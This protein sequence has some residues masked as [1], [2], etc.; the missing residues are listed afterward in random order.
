MINAERSV[1][2]IPRRAALAR[3]VSVSTTAI[4]LSTI[5]ITPRYYA[6]RVYLS[7]VSAAEGSIDEAI[8]IL[9]ERPE[10]PV[11]STRMAGR[12]GDNRHMSQKSR[13]PRGRRRCDAVHAADAERLVRVLR[14]AD[15]VEL[16]GFSR[17]TPGCKI[18][19][20]GGSPVLIR[21]L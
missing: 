11:G 19:F 4:G 2:P 14:R 7:S 1:S 10:H 15:A 8:L 3:K 16:L 9:D 20:G 18:G 21:S 12:Q 5:A 13:R 17:L 6:I